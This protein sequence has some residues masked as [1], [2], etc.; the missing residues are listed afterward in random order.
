MKQ[1]FYYL[2]RII[3]YYQRQGLRGTFKYLVVNGPHKWLLN[4]YH[5]ATKGDRYPQNVVFIAGLAKGGSTWLYHLFSSLDGFASFAPARW[6]AAAG[7]SYS[8]HDWD[9]YP[10]L[11]REF[12]RHLAVIRGH[13]FATPENLSLLRENQLKTIVSVRDPRDVTISGYWYFR[14]SRYHRHYA[15]MQDMSPGD[16]ITFMLDSGQLNEMIL[17]WMRSWLDVRD[18][19][20]I[21]LIRYEDLLLDTGGELARALEFLAFSTSIKE[22]ERMVERNRFERVAGRKRGEEDVTRFL[23]KGV[24]GEWKEVFST[25]Q[26]KQF[27]KIGEDVIQ[28]L[29]YEPTI[30]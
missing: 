2:K 11:F 19:E 23:R 4:S 8:I 22:I 6:T 30:V 9:L 3:T 14:R 24:A 21:H 28:Q 29:R 13:T 5:Y 1:L 27:A 25:D 7:R 18:E 12:R 10:D 15:E 26:K 16:Y 17:E 20:W